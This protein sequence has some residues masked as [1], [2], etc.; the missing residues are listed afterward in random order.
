MRRACVRGCA[1]RARGGEASARVLGRAGLRLARLWLHPIRRLHAGRRLPASSREALRRPHAVV[2]AAVIASRRGT[3]ASRR[4]T[5]ALR[6]G[7]PGGRL[8][9][10]TSR[11]LI[12]GWRSSAA[13]PD[14][15]PA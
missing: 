3:V 7:L 4:G 10:R 6:E 12:P 11:E 13:A 9:S 15:P 14:A 5:V 1:R 2:A 8:R